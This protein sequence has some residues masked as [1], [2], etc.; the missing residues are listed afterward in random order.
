[1][2]DFIPWP[3]TPR[4]FRDVTITE[5]IDGTNAAVHIRRGISISHPSTFDAIPLRPGEAYVDGYV[6]H[7]GAQSRNRLIYPG[8]STDNSG[9]AAWVY[10][11]ARDLV[12]H[13][14][15][16]LHYGEWW[17]CGI[18]RNYGL[19]GRRFSLFNTDKWGDLDVQVGG[20]EVGPVPVLWRGGFDTIAIAGTLA[21]LRDEGSV[22]APGFMNPEGIVV[23]HH[24]SRN[25]F[26]VTLD[27]QD[28][29]KWESE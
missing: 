16:G 25:V 10:A 2:F 18:N 14:G 11:N 9:F 3:K 13:L 15:E 20:V 22:A 4:L 23:F 1:M 19:E 29:G 7:V 21:K 12:E 6:W 26:K 17:G 8:K 27:K 28:A 5:K 24:A